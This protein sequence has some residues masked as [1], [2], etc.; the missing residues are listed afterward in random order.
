MEAV[1]NEQNKM[2]FFPAFLLIPL[3]LQLSSQ[4][5]C[6]TLFAQ[7]SADFQINEEPESPQKGLYE[8]V[9]STRGPKGQNMLVLLIAV[10]PTDFTRDSM[11][12]LAHQLNED[13]KDEQ[14]VHA[15]IFDSP[16]A[17]KTYRNTWSVVNT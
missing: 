6:P 5:Q 2:A 14:W 10:T 7:E 3:A 17:A 15:A 4:M 11:I 9:A 13:F 1:G 8:K 16:T 12:R